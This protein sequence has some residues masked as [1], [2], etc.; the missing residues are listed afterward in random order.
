MHSKVF[1][2][3]TGSFAAILAGLEWSVREDADVLSLSFGI[4]CDESPVY[5]RDLVQPAR[6]AQEA[7]S[8]VVAS[9][10]NNGEGCSSSPG[11]VYD[12]LSVGAVDPEGNVPGFSS[13]ERINTSEAWGDA[14]PSDWPSSY[15][16]PDVTA[17]GVRILS[18]LPDGG[19]GR[20]D[21]TSMAAPHVSGAAALV[22]SSTDRDLPP[23]EHRTVIVE[24]AVNGGEPDPRRGVGEV[25]AYAAVSAAQEEVDTD[26]P[27]PVNTT[28]AEAEGDVPDD[29]EPEDLP[30][31]TVVAALFALLAVALRKRTCDAGDTA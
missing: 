16:V 4:D 12:S 3:G 23:L 2:G 20:M 11:N 19:Y 8:F 1:D 26:E 10:G 17:P 29:E 18:A 25:D 6:N 13:G 31:F 9:T 24:T 27:L 22:E 5:V 21:G 30:G 14:A 28:D 7:G 15:V